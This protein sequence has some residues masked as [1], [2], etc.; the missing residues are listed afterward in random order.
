M[1]I[2]AI[3]LLFL[4]F[5]ILKNKE[6]TAQNGHPKFKVIAFYT[7]KNDAAHIS[8]VHEANQF[9]PK[10]A[11]KYHFSYDSTNNWQNMIL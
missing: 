4:A 7:A 8:F 6:I 3:T 1:K 11:K 5:F 9:F 2:S 10:M